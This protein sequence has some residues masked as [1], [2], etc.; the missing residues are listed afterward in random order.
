MHSRLQSIRRLS[1][2]GT[3]PPVARRQLTNPGTTVGSMISTADGDVF[4][5]SLPDH[6]GY[7]SVNVDEGTPLLVAGK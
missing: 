7:T 6:T 4:H 3:S 1:S 2:I 5:R